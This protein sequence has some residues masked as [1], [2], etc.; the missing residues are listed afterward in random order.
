MMKGGH[1]NMPLIVV[2][3]T[4][5]LVHPVYVC[6]CVCVHA[7]VHAYVCVCVCVCMHV[8]VCVRTLLVYVCVQNNKIMVRRY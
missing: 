5:H 6:V 2:H 8:C 7:C 3:S 4:M 1:G